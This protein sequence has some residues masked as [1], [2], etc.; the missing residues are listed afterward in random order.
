MRYYLYD[1]L[2]DYSLQ[3][4]KGKS[5]FGTLQHAKKKAKK[6]VT[7]EHDSRWRQKGK[8]VEGYKGYSKTRMEYLITSEPLRE[9]DRVNNPKSPSHHNAM[10]IA[11]VGFIRNLQTS[12]REQI[13]DA[14]VGAKQGMNDYALPA[15]ERK[16]FKVILPILRKE[17]R[18]FETRKKNPAKRFTAKQ[19][20]ALKIGFAG[21]KS[22]D[23]ENPTYSKLTAMLDSYSQPMIKQLAKANIKFLS[24]LAR[25]RIERKG[26]PKMARKKKRSAKQLANDKRLGR[27]AKV[28][29]KT[30]RKKT[31]R[32]RTVGRKKTTRKKNVHATRKRTASKKSHLWFAFVCDDKKV[33]YAYISDSRSANVGITP[34]RSAAAIFQT[35]ARATNVANILSRLWKTKQAGVCNINTSAAK[36]KAACNAGK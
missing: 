15:S 16:F 36:I 20:A 17:L 22:V 33:H 18:E 28:R 35:K 31:G 13:E 3:L 19:L 12:N 24:G 29:A 34:T 9:R 5:D 6:K 23:P 26:N 8:K 25:N 1:L 30:R 11:T 21:I 27:M 2:P 14:I 10:W 32:K 4:V 7:W